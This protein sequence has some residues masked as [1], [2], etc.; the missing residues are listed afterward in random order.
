MEQQQ[1]QQQ[2]AAA[3][4]LRQITAFF[5]KLFN[6]KMAHV[7]EPS[8]KDPLLINQAL[9]ENYTAQAAVFMQR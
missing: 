9:Q 6:R 5:L 3:G 8:H 2:Q 1:Q 7:S 4:E